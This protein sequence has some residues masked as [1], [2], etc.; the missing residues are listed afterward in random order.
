MHGSSV[1][2]T[3]TREFVESHDRVPMRHHIRYDVRQ[4]GGGGGGGGPAWVLLYKRF[5]ALVRAEAVLERVRVRD[6]T[7]TSG[8]VK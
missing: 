2:K 7:I 5:V 8:R 3:N 4:A 6:L 1:N